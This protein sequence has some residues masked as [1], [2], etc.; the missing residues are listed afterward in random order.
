[1]PRFTLIIRDQFHSNSF[2]SCNSVTIT[3]AVSRLWTREQIVLWRAMHLIQDHGR[4]FY[5][6]TWFDFSLW[7]IWRQ[8]GPRSN[9]RKKH[10]K[11][12]NTC[13]SYFFAIL[14]C[15]LLL[16]IDNSHNKQTL[17]SKLKQLIYLLLPSIKCSAA[18]PSFRLQAIAKISNQIVEHSSDNIAGS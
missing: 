2:M 11:V 17:T 15:L 12:T 10:Q 16:S 9:S 13:N 8:L 6:I 7:A 18:P 1:M 3:F 14:R 4:V 5:Y